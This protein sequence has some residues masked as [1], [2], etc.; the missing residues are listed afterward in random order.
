MF[1]ADHYTDT[2]PHFSKIFDLFNLSDYLKDF[3]ASYLKLSFLHDGTS[4]NIK[5]FHDKPD[6]KQSSKFQNLN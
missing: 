3:V 2:P 5:I 4:I 1:A 6:S